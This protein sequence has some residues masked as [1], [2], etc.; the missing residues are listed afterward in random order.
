MTKLKTLGVVAVMCCAVLWG[1]YG[2]ILGYSKPLA[3]PITQRDMMFYKMGAADAG[4]S[5]IHDRSL[6]GNFKIGEICWS[7]FVAKFQ[8]STNAP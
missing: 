1:V 3:T 7:N 4:L 5:I 6:I 2:Q 8:V